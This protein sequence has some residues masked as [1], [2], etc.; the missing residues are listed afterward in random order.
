MSLDQGS[1][2]WAAVNFLVWH[3]RCNAL[4]VPDPSHRVWSDCENAIKDSG[5][6]PSCLAGVVLLNLDIGPWAQS[7]RFAEAK[8]AA[9]G[10]FAHGGPQL[11]HLRRLD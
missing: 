3:K 4:V 1:D 10:V 6:W 11:S 7:K 9:W 2:G 8:Q 5:L